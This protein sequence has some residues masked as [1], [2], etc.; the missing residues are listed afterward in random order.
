[1]NMLYRPMVVLLLHFPVNLVYNFFPA[2][3]P[4]SQ[5]LTRRCVLLRRIWLSNVSNITEPD[6]AV[7][8]TQGV[9]SDSTVRLTSQNLTRKFGLHRWIWLGAVW[10]SS[11]NLTRRCGPLVIWLSAVAQHARFIVWTCLS[12]SKLRFRFS[13]CNYKNQIAP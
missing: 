11:Q 9:E 8:S 10:P 2:L 12:I 7:R 5:N 6:F 4:P 13:M 3:S 1:M